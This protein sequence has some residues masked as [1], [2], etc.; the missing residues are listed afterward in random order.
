MAVQPPDAIL[1]R[2]A[3]DRAARIQGFLT[4]G[5]RNG[6]E[7]RVVERGRRSAEVRNQHA[8]SVFNTRPVLPK[9]AEGRGDPRASVDRQ[10][11]DEVYRV[12]TRRVRRPGQGSHR[13]RDGACQCHGAEYTAAMRLEWDRIQARAYGLFWPR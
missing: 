3:S 12:C 8:L 7:C 6:I 11:A 2:A 5:P 1:S 13:T 9:S 10:R 4:N